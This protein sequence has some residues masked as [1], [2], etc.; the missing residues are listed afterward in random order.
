M[1][2]MDASKRT[3]P[4]VATT[5]PDDAQW[6]DCPQD[7]MDVGIERSVKAFLDEVGRLPTPWELKYHF[8]VGLRAYSDDYLKGEGEKWKWRP[9]RKSAAKGKKGKFKAVTKPQRR[10]G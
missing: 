4:N 5:R 6:G 9:R 2:W 3:L 1:G 10:T 8:L 7:W